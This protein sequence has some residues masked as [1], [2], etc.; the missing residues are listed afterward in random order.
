MLRDQLT[1]DFLQL[2]DAIELMDFFRR[3]RRNDSRAI[4]F[5]VQMNMNHYVHAKIWVDE[6]RWQAKELTGVDQNEPIVSGV[7]KFT[8]A[9]VGL[10]VL[11]F[12]SGDAS[13]QPGALR[14][15]SPTQL[16]AEQ[17]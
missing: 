7:S 10:F 12:R 14:H 13:D 9:N 15:Y 4:R 5:F 16:P 3:W 6:L 1:K 11:S 8:T 2:K 17:P